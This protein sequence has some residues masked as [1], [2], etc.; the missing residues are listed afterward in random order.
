VCFEPDICI[1]CALQARRSVADSSG[2]VRCLA[3]GKAFA[4][5]GPLEQHI[6]SS[7]AGVNSADV[8]EVEAARRAAGERPTGS[9]RHAPL[10]LSD[11]LVRACV[12]T[13]AAAA[14]LLWG[15]G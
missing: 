3:C 11:L 10:M 8:A 1:P 6:S 5:Y 14:L 9:A 13:R 4:G 7:H 12:R 2:R 15:G